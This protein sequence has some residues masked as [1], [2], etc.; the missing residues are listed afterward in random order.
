MDS[1]LDL[2]K[3]DVLRERAGLSYRDAVEYLERAKGDVVKA[4]VLVEEDKHE[5]KEVIAEKGQEAFERVKEAVR[6]GNEVKIKIDRRGE[7]LIEI[8]VTV[9]LIGTAVAP[10]LALAGAAVALAT[11][12]SISVKHPEEFIEFEPDGEEDIL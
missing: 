4:L 6:K 10:Y 8:P 12:C 9:G 3:V 2:D 5:K 7:S 11:G 1:E